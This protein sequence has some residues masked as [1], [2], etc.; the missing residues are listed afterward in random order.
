MIA[1][2]VSPPLFY[3][4]SDPNSLS[5]VNHMVPHPLCPQAGQLRCGEVEHLA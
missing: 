4:D 3:R 5:S 2:R 1:Q